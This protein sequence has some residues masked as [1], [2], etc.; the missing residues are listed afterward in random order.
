MISRNN[1][2]QPLTYIA[3]QLWGYGEEPFYHA[4][5][6]LEGV[7][8]TTIRIF[9][10]NIQTSAQR[11]FWNVNLARNLHCKFQRY[12]EVQFLAR[13]FKLELTVQTKCLAREIKLEILVQT[14]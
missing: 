12:V 1:L 4:R 7:S 13:K 6:I 14:Q 2:Q 5:R 11:K 8:L 10:A 3:E 9:G